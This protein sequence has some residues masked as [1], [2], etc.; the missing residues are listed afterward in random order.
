MHRPHVL[1]QNLAHSTNSDVAFLDLC[2]KLIFKHGASPF[3]AREDGK[4]AFEIAVSSENFA[5]IHLFVVAW[6][7]V[8]SWKLHDEVYKLEE[9]KVMLKYINDLVM[10]HQNRNFVVNHI[11]NVLHMYLMV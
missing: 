10:Q 5:L 6:L 11:L 8:P 7:I 9:N 1:L 4:T 2:A 3:C